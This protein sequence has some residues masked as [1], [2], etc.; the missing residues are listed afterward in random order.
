[1]YAYNKSTEAISVV[2]DLLQSDPINP[3][4]LSVRAGMAERVL[5]WEKVISL[6]K[7]IIKH[8]PW[9]ATNYYKLGRAYKQVN[10]ITNMNIMRDKVISFAPGTAEATSA[11]SDLVS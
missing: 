6:R 2:D 10:D 5:D 8:D 7:L 11:K 3:D 4:Y 1:M 9:N